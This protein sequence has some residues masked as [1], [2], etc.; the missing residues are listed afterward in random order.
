MLFCLEKKH[1]NDHVC[2]AVDV[3]KVAW[4]CSLVL[5]GF[6]VRLWLDEND[7]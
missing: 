4:Q 2:A 5:V 1:Q 7:Q 6:M 3:S